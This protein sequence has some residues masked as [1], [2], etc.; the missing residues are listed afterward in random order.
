MEFL[1]IGLI[2]RPHGV[3]GALKLLPLTDNT[4][5]FLKLKQAYIE[6]DGYKKLD[7]KE[8]SVQADSVIIALEGIDTREQA[9]KLRDKYICVDRK[10]AVKLPEFTYFI[11]DLIDC[12]VS[13]TDGTEYGELTEVLQTG[14]NDVYVISGEKTLLVPAL[15]RLLNTVDIQNKRIVLNNDVLEEVG[16]F[17]D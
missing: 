13:G 8:I 11:A 6:Q 1:R 12:H 2:V 14:A 3:H 16:L 9:E 7:I 15:K 10:N 17:E 4:D 5:R